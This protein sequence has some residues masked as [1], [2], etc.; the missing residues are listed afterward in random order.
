VLYDCAHGC[1][2]RVTVAAL[3]PE[4][5]YYNKHR[6]MIQWMAAEISGAALLALAAF[7]G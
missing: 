3:A 7:A 4:S 6:P 2:T 5:I 1:D